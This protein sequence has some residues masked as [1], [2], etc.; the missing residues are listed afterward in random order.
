MLRRSKRLIL[1]L[2]LLAMGLAAGNAGAFTLQLL[3]LSDQEGDAESI[4]DMPN[5]GALIDYFQNEGGVENTVVLSSGDLFI[6]GAFFNAGGDADYA[7]QDAVREATGNPDAVTRRIPGRVDMAIQNILGIQASALGNHDFDAGTADL[8]DMIAGDASDATVNWEGV[9]FPYLSANLDFSQDGEMEPLY[10][11]DIQ[12]VN[13]FF[14]ALDDPAAIADAKKLAPVAYIEIE[15]ADR[16]EP[17]RIGLVGATT[18]MLD[19]ISRPAPTTVKNPGAGTNNMQDLASILQ[20]YI[21]QLIA[22]GM[23]KIILLAHMQQIQYEEE[24]IGYLHGVDIVISGGS[25]S[26]LADQEDIDRG[27]MRPGDVNNIYKSYPIVTQNADGDPALIV[28]TDGQY[29]YLGR[30]VV[31]FDDNGVIDADSVDENVSGAFAATDEQVTALYGVIDAAYTEGSKAARVKTIT[32]AVNTVI[33]AKDAEIHGKTAVYL[34]GERSQ[35][36]TE[37]TNLGVLAGTAFIQQANE[38]AA[39]RAMEPVDVAL[40]NGGGIRASIGEILA[41]PGTTDYSYVPPQANPISGRKEGE[42]SRLAIETTFKYSNKLSMLSLTAENFV[43]IVEHSVAA[44]G[45][46]MVPGQFGQY[47]GA[48]FSFDPSKPAGERVWNLVLLDTDATGRATGGV[49]DVIVENGELQGDP[50]RI[51]RM[52]TLDFLANGGDSYPF[53]DLVSDRYDSDLEYRDAFQNYM[54]TYY[55]TT[56]AGYDVA[57]TTF[58]KDG[59]IRNMGRGGDQTFNSERQAPAGSDVIE[60]SFKSRY[61]ADDAD[62]RGSEIVAYDPDGEQLFVTNGATGMV[63]VLDMSNPA[64][65]TL[66]RTLSV[67]AYG[68]PT[69]VAVKNGMVAVAVAADPTQNNGHIV[70][71]DTDGNFKQAVTAGAL[72]DMVAFSPDGNYALSACEGEPNDDYSVDPEGSVAVIDVSGGLDGALTANLAGFSSFNADR[73]ELIAAGVRIFGNNGLATVAQDVEPEY[74]AVT[75]DSSTAFVTLQENN[76]VAVVDIATATVTSILPLGYKDHSLAQ[77]GLDASDKDDAINIASYARLKGMYM[78]DSAAC[79]QVDGKTYIV[80]A[81]EGDSRDYD[82]YSEETRVKDL[83]LDPTAFPYADD[84]QKDEILG[85]LKTTLAN[86]DIDGDGDFDE[87]YSYGARSF[88]IFEYADGAL[89]QVYDSAD[90]FERIIAKLMPDYFNQDEGEFDGRSD[91][92][93]VEPEALAIGE[94]GDKTFAFIGLERMSGVMVYDITNPAESS[95][96]Q[97]ISTQNFDGDLEAG[98]AGDIAPEGMVFIPNSGMA[99]RSYPDA[100]YLA[101]ASEDSGSTTLLEIS[102]DIVP[103]PARGDDDDSDSGCVL[104]PAAGPSFEWLLVLLAPALAILRRRF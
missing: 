60:L 45:P 36:R 71:F 46:D 26:I 53:A 75:P 7:I 15:T 3:H 54:D 97:Y 102:G 103:A 48:A 83:T 68:S 77:N 87:I 2:A 74:I 22:A 30:L 31:D 20:P 1:V 9:K 50:S 44:A 24:L 32:D 94:I 100:P 80:T 51:V 69:S 29:K 78:P 65:L 4:D 64:N 73:A 81:N 84:L 88:S 34:N 79:Y 17:E 59:L 25:D 33:I 66:K 16:A 14:A 49:K 5:M 10:T 43:K 12:N 92:K 42:I 61:M 28:N 57:D 90:D 76:A 95:F 72:P 37:E 63:D 98:T 104:N 8:Y 89:T 39:A 23:D 82:T 6:P 86:G 58:D 96:V 67:G 11:A 52:V 18:P 38:L 47:A 91:D 41:Q 13:D 85:R 55:P 27:M 93:G 70:F 101:M 21:N 99:A 62:E 35:V 19:S 40:Q 56:S